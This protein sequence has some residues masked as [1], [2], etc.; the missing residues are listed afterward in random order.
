M[1]S[2]K[3]YSNVKVS[4]KSFYSDSQIAQYIEQLNNDDIIDFQYVGH[5]RE[6]YKKFMIV[7]KKRKQIN[8]IEGYIANL[9]E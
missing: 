2:Y 3:N 9:D 4:F 5:E 8:T 7:T 1:A 6:G